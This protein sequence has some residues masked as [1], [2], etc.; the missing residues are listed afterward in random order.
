MLSLIFGFVLL[1]FLTMMSSFV[2]L[3]TFISSM[4]LILHSINYLNV[5]FS[6]D[7]L[8]MNIMK[9]IN[10]PIDVLIKNKLAQPKF[11]TNRPT[12]PPNEV[13]PIESIDVN[14]AI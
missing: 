4:N 12:Q 8:E 9:L 5:I 1:L 2:K 3:K 6:I 14:K 11:A 7:F 10:S 13:L